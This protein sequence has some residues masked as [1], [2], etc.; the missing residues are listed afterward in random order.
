[1][2]PKNRQRTV[3]ELLEKVL[4]AGADLINYLPPD[5]AFQVEVTFGELVVMLKQ[6]ALVQEGGPKI[7]LRPPDR[8]NEVN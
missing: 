3:H 6:G 1:M 2:D 5:M 4:D 7:A 8:A